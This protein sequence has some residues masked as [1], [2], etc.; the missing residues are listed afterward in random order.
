M[1]AGAEKHLTEEGRVVLV[2]RKELD[3][4]RHV[5]SSVS[6]RRETDGFKVVETR[7]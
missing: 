6:L 2:H 3:L 7:P 1:L 5:S 4:S